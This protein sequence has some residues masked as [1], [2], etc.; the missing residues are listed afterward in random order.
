MVHCCNV[1][2]A[3]LPNADMWHLRTIL[4]ITTKGH[5]RS[6]TCPM[7]HNI[8]S[9]RCTK[10]LIKLHNAN[11]FFYTKPSDL[12]SGNAEGLSVQYRIDPCIQKKSGLGGFGALGSGLLSIL[13][14]S[15]VPTIDFYCG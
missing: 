11:T 5:G 9:K 12:K 15:I 14:Y 7:H 1:I 6:A 3:A 8:H 10:V 2:D 4:T 13:G